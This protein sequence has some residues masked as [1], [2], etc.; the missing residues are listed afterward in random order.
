MKKLIICL[1]CLMLLLSACG[2]VTES[3]EP[4]ETP[5]ATPAE[6]EQAAPAEPEPEAEPVHENVLPSGIVVKTDYSKLTGYDAGEAIYT[7]VFEEYT[8]EL[9]PSGDYGML[10]PFI[11]AELFSDYGDGYSWM[12][13]RLYGLCDDFGRIVVDPVYCSV[14]QVYDYA[15]Y[16]YYP[17][18][19][20]TKHNPDYVVSEYEYDPDSQL[21]RV[22][23]LDGSWICENDY[24]Y[25]SYNDGY[26]VCERDGVYDI[27]DGAGQII[28]RSEEF[29][30][31]NE[32]MS[33]KVSGITVT[34][35]KL[36]LTVNEN[37]SEWY[38]TDLYGNM[39]FGPYSQACEFSCGLASASPAGSE[40]YGY[41]D[42]EGSW[43][44][45]PQFEY[46]GSFVD[47]LASVTYPGGAG[48][49]I[50]TTGMQ[51]FYSD[52]GSYSVEQ[53]WIRLWYYDEYGNY[54]TE[55]YDL[56]FDPFPVLCTGETALNGDIYYA[57]DDTG[58]YLLNSVTGEKLFYEGASYVSPLYVDMMDIS[59]LMMISYHS[60]DGEHY[61]NTGTIY[62][63]KHGEVMTYGE[64]ES[65]SGMH[66][67]VTD[68]YYIRKYASADGSNY[69]SECVYDDSGARLGV[70]CDSVYEV[71]NGRFLVTDGFYTGYQDAD[72]NWLFRYPLLSS[73]TD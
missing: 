3:P 17:Y 15:E 46:A 38:Y 2:S 73:M 29:P 19:Y 65:V 51:Y 8:D 42:T 25:I 32:G 58:A 52:S 6:P 22:A 21:V 70:N 12:S 71:I 67:P 45:E 7:R 20:L 5:E 4:S 26:F 56:S 50:D 10:Y 11:G 37:Y 53:K 61:I 55:I 41:I 57:G 36:C 16:S 66:D 27:L 39:L 69:F 35:G 9:I 24:R 44:I 64:N 18:Y 49:I 31:A 13:G 47:G 48:A 30:I 1:L 59:D 34:D 62:S 43:A 23:A 68:S 28:S 14:E 60:E 54:V 33:G 63:A 40:L 72:G